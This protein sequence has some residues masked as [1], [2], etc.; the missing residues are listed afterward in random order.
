VQKAADA[1]RYATAVL[2]T[3]GAGLGV[4]SGLPDFRYGSCARVCPG[5]EP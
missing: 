2:F 4:D 1:L 3:S 5:V